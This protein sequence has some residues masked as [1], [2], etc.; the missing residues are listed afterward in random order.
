[1]DTTVCLVCTVPISAS[2]LGIEACR[3]CAAFFKRT[4]IA[5]HKFIC[6]QG[7]RKCTIRKH[8]KFMCRSCRYDRCIQLGMAYE[9][10]KKRKPRKNKDSVEATTSTVSTSTTLC[11]E[12]SLLGRMEAAYN[13]SYERRLVQE[14]EYCIR[15]NLR[16]FN[17]PTKELFLSSFTAYYE[18]FRITITESR[19]ILQNVFDDFNSFPI[20]HRVIRECNLI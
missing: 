18:L 5:G 15:H 8:E 14:K 16:S 10:P 2:H 1:M 20:E 12:R 17:H 9:Q 19:S 13:A 11:D 7:D 6:R 4:V 3:A